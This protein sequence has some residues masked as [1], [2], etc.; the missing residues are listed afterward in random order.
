MRSRLAALG[1]L[2]VLSAVPVLADPVLLVAGYDVRP[3]KETQFLDLLKKYDQPMF[4]KL[5]KEGAVLA[6][7]VDAVALHDPAAGATHHLWWISP[8]NA[9]LDKVFAAEAALDAQIGADDE[10]AGQAAKT[11]GK[12]APK[13]TFAR[14]FESFDLAKHRDSLYRVLVSDG[15]PA[16]A[17]GKPYIQVTFAKAQPGKGAEFRAAW[18][19]HLKPIVDKLM[20]DG[21]L[22]GYGLTAA[23]PRS[24]AFTHMGWVTFPNLAARDKYNA[25]FDARPAAAVKEANDA[26]GSTIDGDATRGLLLRSIIF[27]SAAPPPR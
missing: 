8:D 19:K 27:E 15:K 11:A 1:G 9:A 12:P 2:L 26:I 20:T 18:E 13:G 24:D 14:I 4:G 21:T 10:K 3:D 16:A 25:A 7:G 17:G 23:S 5:M 6:W 22:I